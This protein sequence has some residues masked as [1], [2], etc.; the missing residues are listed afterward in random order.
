MCD[1]LNRLAGRG[2][3]LLCDRDGRL[4]N[5]HGATNLPPAKRKNTKHPR[6]MRYV[7]A[8]AELEKKIALL[9]WQLKDSGLALAILYPPLNTLNPASARECIGGIA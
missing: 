6:L 8:A 4:I 2:Y 5:L 9:N 3:E 1:S 7:V